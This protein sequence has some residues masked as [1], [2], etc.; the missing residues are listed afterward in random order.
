MSVVR[1]HQKLLK[2]GLP[3]IEALEEEP[4]GRKADA[5]LRLNP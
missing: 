3:V 5:I 1:V 4:L 2:R